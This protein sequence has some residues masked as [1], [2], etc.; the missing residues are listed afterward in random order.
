MNL[1]PQFGKLEDVSFFS[2]LPCV[3]ELLGDEMH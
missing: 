3:A 1:Q 2:P